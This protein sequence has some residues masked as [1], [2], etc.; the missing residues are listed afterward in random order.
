M[1]Q[2]GVNFLDHCEAFDHPIDISGLSY[3]PDGFMRDCS[4]FNHDFVIP[5]TIVSIG[6]WALANLDSMTGTIIVEAPASVVPGSAAPY[7]F[8][9][10]DT[11]NPCYATG[12]TLA[13]PYAQD[14]HT[15]FADSSVWP[16]RKTIV[17]NQ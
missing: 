4:S 14:W 11:S 16:Y 10:S 17:S 6:H 1:T 3:L 5:S 9:T 13:G 8:S 12:I 2:V 7:I 15:S